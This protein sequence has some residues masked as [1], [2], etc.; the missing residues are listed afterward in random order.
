VAVREHHPTDAVECAWGLRGIKEDPFNEGA[1]ADLER[2]DDLLFRTSAAT[3]LEIAADRKHLG[4]TYTIVLFC[5][6]SHDSS[7][8]SVKTTS[9]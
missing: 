7:C 9:C 6:A 3:L 4:A 5:S 1:R 2:R 8:G